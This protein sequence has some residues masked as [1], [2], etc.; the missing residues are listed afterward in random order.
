MEDFEQ[1]SDINFCFKDGIHGCYIHFLLLLY[2]ITG[3]SW[4]LRG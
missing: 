2:Q 4:R 3:L 1:S